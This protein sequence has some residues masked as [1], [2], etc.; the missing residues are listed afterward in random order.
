MLA[1]WKPSLPWLLAGGLTPANVAEA[2]ALSG[3]AGVDVSSGVESAPGVKDAT[4]IRGFIKASRNAVP[5][6]SAGKRREY[7]SADQGVPVNKHFAVEETGPA[8]VQAGGQNSL[9]Q[10]P[11]ERGRF[12]TFG[13]RFVAET[14]MP[15]RAGCRARL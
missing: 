5:A 9:R 4:L 13:G 8:Q 10:G 6:L 2:I 12:G 1:G 7:D 14:L 15:A 3:A 11:D